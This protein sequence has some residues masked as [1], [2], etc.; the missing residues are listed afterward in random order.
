MPTA[1]VNGVAIVDACVNSISSPG[2]RQ[3]VLAAFSSGM[4]VEATTEERA[5]V[6]V[7][8]V[9]AFIVNRVKHEENKNN[10][11]AVESDFRPAQ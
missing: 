10:E 11:A 8:E 2:L 9:R 7:R 3:R 6:F 5:A 1:T 4:P